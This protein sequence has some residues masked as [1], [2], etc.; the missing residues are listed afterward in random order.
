VRTHLE[1]R[2]DAFPACPGEEEEINPGRYGKRLAEYLDAGLPGLGFPTTG[3]WPEDWGWGVGIK[4]DAFPLW[5]GV[6]NYEEYDDGFL[7]FIEPSKPVISRWFK[8]IPTADTVE[9]LADALEKLIRDSDGVRNVRW[10]D[11]KEAGRGR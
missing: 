8:R 2:S 1:F 6:G 9:R 4:H 11:E 3:I 7:C 10:W 5:I